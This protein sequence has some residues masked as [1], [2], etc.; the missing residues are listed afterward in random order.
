MALDI[1]DAAH[2]LSLF[3]GRVIVDEVSAAAT[4]GM[5]CAC[6]FTWT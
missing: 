5:L 6:I 3:L 2:M 4:S 1:P